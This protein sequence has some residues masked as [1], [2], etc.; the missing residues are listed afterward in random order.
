MTKVLRSYFNYTQKIFPWIPWFQWPKSYEATSTPTTGSLF[1]ESG[2]FSD[3]S[4][5]KLLQR[6]EMVFLN[7]SMSFSDQSLTKLLQRGITIDNNNLDS[8]SDQSLTKLLQQHV[9]L[10]ITFILNV[11]VTKVLR[12]YFNLKRKML[13][14]QPTPVSVTKVLRSY[15]NRTGFAQQVSL[16]QFQWPKSYEATSTKGSPCQEAAVKSF[17]DQSLTK[18]LQ[19]Y[20]ELYKKEREEV[21][22]T[23]VL[24]SYFNF[25]NKPKILG[26]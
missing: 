5:T 10:I 22:V 25:L 4:L 2:C 6:P 7:T 16:S 15:F 8:F 18:L 19:L 26:L 3:Q 1:S 12:S 13:L 23:K 9:F 21:S 17:S 20:S 11:S 14:A 24:R